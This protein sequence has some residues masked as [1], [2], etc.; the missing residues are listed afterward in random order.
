MALVEGDQYDNFLEAPEDP[1]DDPV[2]GNRVL[3]KGGDDTIVGSSNPDGLFGGDGDDVIDAKVNDEG[4]GDLL[5]GGDGADDLYGSAGDDVINGDNVKQSDD[6]DSMA[7][8]DYLYGGA[9]NDDLRGGI[10]DDTYV[11]YMSDG[12]QDTIKEDLS[13]A[14]STGFGGGTDAVFMADV[15]RADIRFDFLGDDLVI[16]NAADAADGTLDSGVVIQDQFAGGDN[17]VEVL[18]TSEGDQISLV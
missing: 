18:F 11:H 4:S 2:T 12:G 10:G 5:S 6:D 15:A 9:G 17:A 1:G 16:S 7:N 8:N 3:G 14:G 13:A